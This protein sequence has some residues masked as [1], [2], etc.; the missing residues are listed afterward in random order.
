MSI[1]A[2]IFLWGFIKHGGSTMNGF[3][4]PK[5]YYNLFGTLLLERAAYYGMRSLI[6][7][8]MIYSLGLDNETAGGIYGLLIGG[9]V[10]APFVFGYFADLIGIKRSTILA[11]A[12]AALG[13]IFL[14]ISSYLMNIIWV[15]IGLAL[16]VVAQ[17]FFKPSVYVLL[18]GLYEDKNDPRR[19]SGFTLM[20]LAINIGAFIA[21][22]I[23]GTLGEKYSWSLG[24]LIAGLFS[25]S[26]IPLLKG[27][28][29]FKYPKHKG[30]TEQEKKNV[31]ALMVFAV[32]VAIMWSV[33]SGYSDFIGSVLAN[34]AGELTSK[35]GF[36]MSI[37]TMSIGVVL[38]PFFVWL[39]VYLHNKG[40]T[41]NTMHKFMFGFVSFSV[42]FM[43]LYFVFIIYQKTTT[44]N[45][46]MMAM[47]TIFS[48]I[49][50]LLVAPIA[51]SLV[52][53]LSPAK[54]AA[55]VIG[56]WY[57]TQL[58][59]RF[60]NSL[61]PEYGTFS[62]VWLFILPVIL[63]AAC[64]VGLYLLLKPLRRWMGNVQ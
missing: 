28:K 58:I 36:W 15:Y 18:G 54:V 46:P 43:F 4:H 47:A 23:C 41:V 42:S 10:I 11:C 53:K 32:F 52:T 60:I 59:S 56:A 51:L 14:S 40:K 2:L 34:S 55:F 7:I 49:A 39:W 45:I 29:D 20:F 33:I 57:A 61:I 16:F 48:A 9:I 44:I 19:D 13:T 62:D 6:M 25:L 21:P 22:F 8:Y 1:V 17:G 35:L 38:I 26:A 63:C 31:Y 5:G 50:E 3:I 27:V 64:V 12:I 37:L 24:F 30:L